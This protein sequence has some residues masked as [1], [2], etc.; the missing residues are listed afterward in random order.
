MRKKELLQIVLKEPSEEL[1]RKAKEDRCIDRLVP[2]KMWTYKNGKGQYEDYYEKIKSYA[3]RLFFTV[4]KDNGI[5][6]I[7]VYGRAQLAAGMTAP[8]FTTYI[9]AENERW[10]TRIGEKWS[11]AYMHNLIWDMR[12]DAN[13]NLPKTDWRVSKDI[14]DK[15]AILLCNEELCTSEETVFKAVK[16]WQE[17]VRGK[18]NDLKV[19]K[20]IEKWD[21]HMALIPPLPEGF[22]KWAEEDGTGQ[23]NFLFYRKKGK[24]TEVYCTHCGKTWKTDQKIVHTKGS[25]T[26]YD[27]KPQEKYFCMRCGEYL[28]AKA[29]GKQQSLRTDDVVVLA[30]KAGEYIAFRKFRV[31]KR[32][33]R[34]NA[35]PIDRWKCKTSI[36]EAFRVL[37]NPYTFHSVASYEQRTVEPIG[38]Y[39]WAETKEG[40]YWNGYYSA[41]TQA[42]SIGR[43]ILY[44]RN[45]K[46]VLENTGVRKEVA[47]LFLSHREE[48]MQYAL[49][50]AAERGYIEYLVKAG[51]KRLAR[52]AVYDA[53][54]IK[55]S[56]AK[57]L[58]EL[59]GING[60]H[61]RTL[62]MLDGNSYTIDALKYIEEHNEKIDDETLQYVTAESV[63]IKNLD[64][65]RTGMTLQRMINYIRK[66]AE[67]EKRGFAATNQMYIDYINMAINRGM[68]P[69]D[70]IV[71]HTSKLRQMHDRYLEEKNAKEA[72]KEKARVNRMFR[73]IEKSFLDNVEHFSFEK[74]GFKIVVP[75]DAEDIKRE[76]RLQH[77]CVGASDRYIK[78]MN[79]GKT[80]ILFLRKEEALETPYYTLEVEYDGKILQ[81]YGAYDRKPDWKKIE[82]ILESFSRQIQKRTE[83]ESRQRARERILVEAV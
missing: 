60:Q 62:R 20:R 73:W 3:T 26:R 13:G 68:D 23:S 41:R 4:Q 34:E 53:A 65:K 61:L 43:G 9:D 74:A 49:E 10:L 37:A 44:L 52:D 6:A 69:T 35:G 16:V 12:T 42:Y 1:V 82:P 24:Q 11:E 59:L 2:M 79:E 47:D 57:N 30:Q 15:N 8:I 67:K 71:R 66:Q 7:S 19:K 33:Q 50:R 58:K 51:L 32:F 78:S 25:P 17:C 40:G 83:K 39:M 80:F 45:I 64:L 63:V 55:N 72:A 28:A 18:E 21:R 31:V 5:L 81:S 22:E 75:R 36:V 38:R 77:H 14:F 70:E 76:G 48:N 46:E 56:D 54:R 29:W 27:Y